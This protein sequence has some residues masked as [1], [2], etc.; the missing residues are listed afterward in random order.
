MVSH[1]TVYIRYCIGS[2]G[3]DRYDL[4]LTDF[5]DVLMYICQHCFLNFLMIYEKTN[6]NL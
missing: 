1:V 3:D 5:M 6:P 2:V 4:V